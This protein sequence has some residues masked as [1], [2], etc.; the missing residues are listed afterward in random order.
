[1]DSSVADSVA[2]P[3]LA[4]WRHLSATAEFQRRDRRSPAV[5]QRG[6]CVARPGPRVQ[7]SE[8]DFVGSKR[9]TCSWGICIEVH[10]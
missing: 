4:Q 9:S 5:L 8:S 3:V 10:T 1:M 6:K 7:G 2:A